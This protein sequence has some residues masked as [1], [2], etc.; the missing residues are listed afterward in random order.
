MAGL[1]LQLVFDTLS[2]ILKLTN[3]YKADYKRY[4]VSGEA[5]WL[6]PA[7]VCVCDI[8]GAACYHS[9]AR[10]RRREFGQV[11]T[12]TRGLMSSDRLAQ[13]RAQHT[14]I[15]HGRRELQTPV[16]VQLTEVLILIN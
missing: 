3:S 14:G 5:L 10:R 16:L 12:L 7:G 9:R 6:K 4:T 1:L 2:E 13:Q 8:G 15:A 11:F